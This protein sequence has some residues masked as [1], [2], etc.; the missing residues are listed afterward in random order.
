M[1][2][3]NASIKNNEVKKETWGYSIKDKLFTNSEKAELKEDSSFNA[4]DITIL[5]SGVEVEV[6]EIGDG[7]TIENGYAYPWLKVRL[8]DRNIQGWILSKFLEYKLTQIKSPDNKLLAIVSLSRGIYGNYKQNCDSLQWSGPIRC[9]VKIFEKEKLILSKEIEMNL[10]GWLDNENILLSS[11]DGSGGGSFTE[12]KGINVMT[13]V[14]QKILSINYL[15]EENIE[16]CNYSN[17]CYILNNKESTFTIF[18][19]SE[20]SNHQI[21]S[22]EKKGK[23]EL[24]IPNLLE[25]KVINIETIKFNIGNEVFELNFNTDQVIE[26][27]GSN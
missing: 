7:E 17:K 27:I 1:K 22:C 25:N 11:Y 15:Q 10:Q 20:S 14:E 23:L 3:E 5:I 13:K 4:K 16:I 19:K 9:F 12:Y 21:F 6:L 24:V 2:K 26:K 18:L 8:K